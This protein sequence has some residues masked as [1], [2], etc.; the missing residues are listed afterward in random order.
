MMKD[1]HKIYGTSSSKMQ[2]LIFRKPLGH[3]SNNLNPGT[4]RG[5]GNRN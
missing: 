1:Y 4:V 3:A 2:I 5:D